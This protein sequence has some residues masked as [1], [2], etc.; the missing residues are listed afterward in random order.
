VGQSRSPRYL[1]QLALREQHPQTW[2]TPSRRVVERQVA[3]ETVVEARDEGPG[4]M[5]SSMPFAPR[6]LK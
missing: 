4:L 5:R 2:P 1:K 6:N 3:H